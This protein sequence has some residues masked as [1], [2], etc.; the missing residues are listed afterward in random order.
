M[1]A[2]GK[3]HGHDRGPCG[4]DGAT[5]CPKLNMAWMRDQLALARRQFKRLLVRIR[6]KV[7]PGLRLVLGILLMIGGVFAFLPVLGL[8]MIPLGIAVAALDVVPMWRW[9]KSRLF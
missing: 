8:W 7:P 6:L 4:L 2:I 5:S 9:I 3:S 1:A